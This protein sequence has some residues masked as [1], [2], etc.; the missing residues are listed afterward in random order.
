MRVPLLK[1]SGPSRSPIVRRD[2]DKEI[3][4]YIFYAGRS[5]PVDYMTGNEKIDVANGIYHYVLGKDRGI[6][7]NISLNKTDMKGLKELRFEKEGFDGL[8]QL[9]EVYNADIEC[10]LNVQAYPGMYIYVDPRG[11]SPEAGINYSQFGI[12]GY[13]MITRAEHSIG[14]GKADT[15][16]TAKWVADTNG[17]VDGGEVKPDTEPQEEQ[18][19]VKPRKCVTKARRNSLGA[20]INQNF[21]IDSVFDLYKYTQPLAAAYALGKAIA[22]TDE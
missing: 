13:Y 11:F 22:E 20:A 21:A 1:T 9:R 4:Y 12:G 2:M 15:K 17:R 18:E 5:Y 6:V 16:I 7:K 19:L 3:N 8:T 14:M 10:F